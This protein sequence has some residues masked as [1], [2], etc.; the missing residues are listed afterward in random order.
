MHPD[1]FLEKW[2]DFQQQNTEL[3]QAV[4][5]QT[6][7]LS[8]DSAVFF[9]Q[10]VGFKPYPY[11]K[12]F[13]D[14][15][16]NNQFTAARWCRQSGK[17]QTISALLLKY[18]VS[19]PDVAIG[20]VGPSWR[21]SK[22]IIARIAAFA[23]KLPAGIAYKPQKTMLHFANGSSIE[24]F[25]NNPETIRGP[26]L[27]VVYADEFNFVANDQD[28]YDAILYTLGTTD[29][30]F[31]CSSTPWH[32]DS[33]FY[34]IFNNKNFSDFKT[35]HVTY[36]QAL[37]PNGPLKPNI[38]GQIKTQMGDDFSR[39]QREMMADWVEDDN[40][41]LNQSLIASCI[42]TEKTLGSDLQIYNPETSHEGDF[43]AGLD[44]AQTKDYHV[45]SVV[46]SVDDK[47]LLRHLK[48]FQHPTYDATVLGYIKTLQDRWG[49]FQKIRVDITRE[50]PSFIADMENAGIENAEGVNFSVPRKSE[51]ASLLKKRMQDG[52]FLYPMM[53]FEKP[54]R[55]DICNELNVERFA[56]RADGGYSFSHPQGTHDDV[57]WSVALA[58]YST[59]DMAPEPYLAVIPR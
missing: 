39:W 33:I 40:V 29:G 11:Q 21:Q 16:E 31:V 27:H 28:L 38:I 55:G 3:K 32:T 9:E 13:I 1:Q 48:I 17:T 12:E 20:V 57:F 41:W 47:L 14:I 44:P 49:G 10:I 6:E 50:G 25:P 26:T 59:T 53:S 24:A 30:K 15:F 36:E 43:Y 23:H 34:K 4:T 5:A 52:R 19:H 37:F 58:I 54:Y 2:R 42:G 8:S 22:R 51:M 45:L 56:L 18:A 7:A 46:E 35:S